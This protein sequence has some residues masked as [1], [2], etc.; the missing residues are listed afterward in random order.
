MQNGEKEIFQLLIVA[1]KEN[2]GD[3]LDKLLSEHPD[4]L[5]QS[6]VLSDLDATEPVYYTP[7]SYAASLFQIDLVARLIEKHHADPNVRAQD[8]STP[9]HKLV[10][11]DKGPLNRTGNAF[12]TAGYLLKKGANPD[13]TDPTFKLDTPRNV[14][15]EFILNNQSLVHWVTHDAR[16][17]L[18]SWYY[19]TPAPDPTTHYRALNCHTA[20]SEMVTGR[21]HFHYPASKGAAA[22][23]AGIGV[24]LVAGVAMAMKR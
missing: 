12:R 15:N 5:N 23:S 9:L 2:K 6:F 11:H 19:K 22:A 20:F 7:L 3:A 1:I 14:A 24:A 4:F 8:N 18:Q 16:Q 13:L 21:F 10:C 17:Q